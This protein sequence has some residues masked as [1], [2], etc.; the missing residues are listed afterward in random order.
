MCYK[1]KCESETE[2]ILTNFK[3]VWKSK[4]VV[5]DQIT[6]LRCDECGELSFRRN[7]VKRIQELLKEKCQ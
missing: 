5:I 2:V 1:C 3:T 6:A 7:E 4:E